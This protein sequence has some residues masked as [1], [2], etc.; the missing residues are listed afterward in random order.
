MG[1]SPWGPRDLS[2][3]RCLPSRHREGWQAGGNCE[4]RASGS[5][6]KEASDVGMVGE[7]FPDLGVIRPPVLRVGHIYLSSIFKQAIMAQLARAL[8]PLLRA[9]VQFMHIVNLY[10]YLNI[11]R[12]LYTLL[13]FYLIVSSIVVF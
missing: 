4:G 3:A 7:P 13:V 11:V 5:G 2:L 12:A 10:F 1:Y 9:W 8:F 6:G